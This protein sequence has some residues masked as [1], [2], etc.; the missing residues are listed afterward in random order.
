[1]TSRIAMIAIDALEPRRVA[2]FWA[3]VLGSRVVE[4]SAAG[5]RIAPANTAWPTIDVLPAPEPK[6][7][8]NRLPPGPAG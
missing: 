2:D 3:A 6:T 1:M 4:D 5:I 8:K 7:V